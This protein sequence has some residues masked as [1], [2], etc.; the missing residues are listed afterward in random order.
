LP[1]TVQIG[2][3]T[4]LSASLEAP[5][6]PLIGVPVEFFLG[7]QPVGVATTTENGLATLLDINANL[8]QPG[9]N[10]NAVRARLTESIAFVRAEESTADVTVERKIPTVSWEAGRPIRYGTPLG[11]DGLNATSDV[12]GEFVYTPEAGTILHAG[13]A[14]LL[15]VR[16]VPADDY[17]YQEVTVSS[18]VDVIPAP[19]TIFVAASSKL[20]LDPLPAFTFKAGGFVNGDTIASLSGTP[21][22]D[23]AATEASAVG[24][25][26]VNASGFSSSDYAIQYE[27]GTLAVLP[28]STETTV[29][30]G[31]SSST[32]GQLLRVLVSVSSTLGT[33]TGSVELLADQTSLAVRALVNGS[34]V[35]DVSGLVPGTHALQARFLGSDN[36][37]GSVSAPVTHVVNRAASSATLSLTPSPSTYGQTI[38]LAARVVTLLGTPATGSVQFRDGTTVLGTSLLLPQ[39]DA[40]VAVLSSS[41]LPAGSHQLSVDYRG[42]P[43]LLPG[44]SP[45]VT[46]TV[47]PSATMVQLVTSPNP[48][49]TG[50]AVTMRAS[51]SATAP[52]G[53]IPSGFVEFYDGATRIG[54]AALVDG[55]GMLVVSSLKSGKHD[56]HAR[57]LAMENYTASVSPVLVHTVKGG[58]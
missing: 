13:A 18:T 22:F 29:T 19:L 49:R 58:K 51:V 56:V 7:D 55:T 45:A 46:T 25:Y 5:G 42:S 6:A 24:G 54:T 20:Y 43:T 57:Y 44:T 16:F 33:P 12:P 41:T 37:T 3:L 47:T 11:A 36:F 30:P 26:P 17:R 21:S 32:F 38:T 14:Q 34:V 9:I 48:S 40:A 8:L 4:T 2:D 53:G 39:G 15:T 35:F 1:L 23:T 10:P 50:E 28:R 31:L 52:G 27:P